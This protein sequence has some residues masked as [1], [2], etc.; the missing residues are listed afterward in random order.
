MK[1][2]F[3]AIVIHIRIYRQL[4]NVLQV[5]FRVDYFHMFVKSHYLMNNLLN[6]N[7][8]FI[9]KNHFYLYIIRKNKMKNE[10]IIMQIYH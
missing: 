3:N 5:I 4:M 9:F 2:K 6:M 7:E 10:K 1:I 8:K